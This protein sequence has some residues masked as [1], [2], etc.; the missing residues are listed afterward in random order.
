MTIVFDTNVV[1]DVVL[2]REPFFADAAA[3]MAYVYEGRIDGLLCGTSLTTVFYLVEQKQGVEGAYA[4]LDRLLD[5]FKAAAV[6]DSVLRSA[7]GLRFADYE[8]AVL[9]ESARR[10]HAD[11]IVTRHTSDFEK[12]TLTVYEPPELLALIEG[13]SD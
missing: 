2:K 9:H 11:G 8:D 13:W 3:L 1:L 5:L 7:R 4:S 10:S 6:D 12:S